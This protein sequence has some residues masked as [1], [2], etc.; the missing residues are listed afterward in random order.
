MGFLN[1]YFLWVK[2][3]YVI[4][5]ILWMVVLFYLLCFFVYYVENVYKKEF[6]GVV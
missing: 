4:V 1:G 3:F 5:V 6:V 2:V